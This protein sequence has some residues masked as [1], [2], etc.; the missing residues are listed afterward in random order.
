MTRATTNLA[1]MVVACMVSFAVPATAKTYADFRVGKLQGKLIVQW[2]EPD[3]FL[4]IPDE[5]NPLT[6]T[7]YDGTVIRPGKM[8]TDGGS[9]PRPIWIL[10]NYSPWGYA[11][12]F[13]IHDW[14]FVVKQCNLRGFEGYSHHDAANVMG[15]VMKTMMESGRVDIDKSTLLSMYL[16]VNSP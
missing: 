1:A 7:R 10:R 15:E 14:L 4:F 8:I 9:I 5:N 16:A 2:L 3:K 6:F 11:P 12:A 13:I